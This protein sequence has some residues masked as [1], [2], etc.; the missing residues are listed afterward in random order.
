MFSFWDCKGMNKILNSKSFLEFFEKFFEI[1]F[2]KSFLLFFALG[3]SVYFSFASYN[4][5][6]ASA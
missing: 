5:C 1:L 2:C 4:K 3:L 6:C